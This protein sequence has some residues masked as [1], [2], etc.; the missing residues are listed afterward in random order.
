MQDSFIRMCKEVVNNTCPINVICNPAKHSYHTAINSKVSNEDAYKY[1][2]EC[3]VR[4]PD[5]K[6]L[7]TVSH[8]IITRADKN[9][10]VFGCYED[11]SNY[12]KELFP[13]DEEREKF[14]EKQFDNG[15]M[16]LV[17]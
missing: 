10:I 9:I 8:V 7:A 3:V 12:Y 15:Y 11:A 17:K 6:V 16:V 5:E 1:F 2:K 14:L 13:V 4:C